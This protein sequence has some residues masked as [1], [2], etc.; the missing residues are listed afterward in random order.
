MGSSS[1]KEI[2]SNG[3]EIPVDTYNHLHDDDICR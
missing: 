3:D 2:D 1:K